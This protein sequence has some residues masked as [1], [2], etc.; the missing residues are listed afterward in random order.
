MYVCLFNDAVPTAEVMEQRK[1]SYRNIMDGV[2]AK[3]YE[4]TVVAN[5]EIHTGICLKGLSKTS[6]YLIL[7]LNSN[8]VTQSSAA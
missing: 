7:W 8:C 5:Y 2:S 6:E 4:K 3:M 1:R